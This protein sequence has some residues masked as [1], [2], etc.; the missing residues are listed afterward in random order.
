[1]EMATKSGI[2]T[3]A[4]CTTPSLRSSCRYPCGCVCRY[5][6]CLVC[7]LCLCTCLCD[8]VRHAMYHL[9]LSKRMTHHNMLACGCARPQ[10][11][12]QPAAAGV[13]EAK[14][15]IPIQ[16]AVRAAK[17]D[18]GM[19][20][21]VSSAVRALLNTVLRM[22]TCDHL[23]SLQRAPRSLQCTDHPERAGRRRRSVWYG[24]CSRLCVEWE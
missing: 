12:W 16:P 10:V 11:T 22:L 5:L 19:M 14:P 1:M 21:C 2:T 15:A 13:Y 9:L 4:F 17:A 8:C 23:E 18:D 24:P 3:A 7:A 20:P 6:A